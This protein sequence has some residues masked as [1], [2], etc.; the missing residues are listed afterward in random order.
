[1]SKLARL[2][3]AV[4]CL[5]LPLAAWSFAVNESVDA[6][7]D[8]LRAGDPPFVYVVADGET[9]SVGSVDGDPIVVMSEAIESSEL[10]GSDV[11]E[12]PKSST[13]ACCWFYWNGIWWCVPCY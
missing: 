8:A 3:A 4:A 6:N 9:I 2:T 5:A 13:T 12:E 1:M 7:A 11:T 10:V